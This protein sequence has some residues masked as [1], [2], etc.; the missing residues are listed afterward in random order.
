VS[1]KRLSSFAG[2]LGLTTRPTRMG[3]AE[4]GGIRIRRRSDLSS[5]GWR[6]R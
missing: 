1:N 6:I 4:G 5:L 2:V 3:A